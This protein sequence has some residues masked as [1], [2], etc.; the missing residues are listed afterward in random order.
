M[1]ENLSIA[2][3]YSL[4]VSEAALYFGIGEKRL[5]AIINEN[6]GADY[7]LEIGTHIRIK[8]EKFEEYLNNA[9]AL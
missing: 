9:T 3:K 8:R 1:K 4:S 7:I 5:R 6:Q 2:H